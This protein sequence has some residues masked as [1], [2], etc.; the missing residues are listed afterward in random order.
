L[1]R[2]SLLLVLFACQ[3]NTEPTSET[4]TETL[5][6]GDGDTDA[7]T[8]AD[9]DSDTD[10]DTVTGPE[11]LFDAEHVLVM[12][13]AEGIKLVANDGSLAGEATWTEMIGSCA[14]CGG[15]GTTADDDGGLLVTYT[16]SGG[17]GTG[18]VAKLNGSTG[19]LG[20]R[21][22]GFGFPHAAV[23][24]PV[25]GSIVVQETSANKLTWIAGDGASSAAVRALT[26]A[27]DAT[28]PGN[29]PNGLVRFQHQGGTYLLSSHRG[30]LGGTGEITMW[31]ISTTTPSLVWEF[32]G[33]GANLD[34]PHSP[35]YRFYDGKW[36]LIW[37]HTEGVS[38]G[39][40]IGLA[41]TSDPL[42]RPAYVA[43][44][45][46]EAPVAPLEYVRGVELTS[47]GML[48]VT[49]SGTGSGP[50]GGAPEGRLISVPMPTDL[51]PTGASGDVDADQE[52]IE[53]PGAV[54][55]LEELDNPFEGWLWMPTFTL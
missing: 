34:T 31:D 7:D 24:D 49:D 12:P 9:S 2:L 44:L 20:F 22:D 13:D 30:G 21:L 19:A 41:V 23:R 15:E 29:S 47:D 1:T 37:A 17:I 36:W 50:F 52:I 18:G 11:L 46:P 55:L 8:D 38:N 42:T 51:A 4:G 10:T 48:Y 26:V 28:W 6:G 14:S 35:R 5:F 54:V 53:I 3:D 32:P 27:G 16:L 40:S 45:V 25:D 33:V 39:G 43:D